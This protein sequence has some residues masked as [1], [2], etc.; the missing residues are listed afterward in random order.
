MAET[1]KKIRYWQAINQTLSAEMERDPRVFTIGEDIAK[2]GGSFG[3]T[4]GL[5]ERFGPA[6]VRDTP[7]SELAIAAAGTGAAMAGMRPVI[8][9]MYMDFIQLALD[10]VVNQAAKMR[11]MSG[12]AYSVPLTIRTLVAARMQSGPQHS[13]S[14]EAWLGGVPGLRVV[15]P[16]TPADAAGLLRTAIRSDDPVV[17]IESLASWRLSESVPEEIVVPLGRAAVRR[18]GC[19]LTMVSFGG[20]VAPTL[21]AAELMAGEG[22]EAEVLDLRSISPLDSRSIL[23]SVARTGALMVVQDGPVPYGVGQAVIAAVAMEDPT[24]LRTRPEVVGPPFSPAPFSPE[25]EGRYFPGSEQI[26]TRA[27]VVAEKVR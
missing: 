4:R 12:G 19:D 14:F 8:E 23:E 13:Q 10:Q 20:A 26:A 6:R 16:T 24:L 3:A 22:V 15:W 11:F 9:I 2:A 18:T 5:L 27:R 1:E 17:F 7:I 21:A 25:L